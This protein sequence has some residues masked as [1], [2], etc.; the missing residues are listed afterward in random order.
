[1]ITAGIV[2]DLPPGFDSLKC[3]YFVINTPSILPNAYA[4]FLSP[5][6]N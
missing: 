2:T 6:A 1:M 4:R 5:L 3:R